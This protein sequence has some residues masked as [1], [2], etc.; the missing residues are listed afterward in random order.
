MYSFRSLQQPQ[1]YFQVAAT[2]F[3]VTTF[4][5]LIRL[6]LPTR[7]QLH[8][9]THA[10]PTLCKLKAPCRKQPLTA[11]ASTRNP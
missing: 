9:S 7:L 10:T 2:T 8:A 4:I 11:L 1:L 5:I 3:L 6:P